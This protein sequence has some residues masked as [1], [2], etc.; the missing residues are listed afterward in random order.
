MVIHKYRNIVRYR[1]M[2]G[3][4]NPT[5]ANPGTQLSLQKVTHVTI[6]VMFFAAIFAQASSCRAFCTKSIMPWHCKGTCCVKDE[7]QCACMGCDVCGT[8]D[9]NGWRQPGQCKNWKARG[10]WHRPQWEQFCNLCRDVRLKK[11]RNSRPG[12]WGSGGSRS[13]S[14]QEVQMQG[15]PIAVPAPQGAPPAHLQ[16]NAA[17]EKI[18]RRDVAEYFFTRA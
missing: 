11:P 6:L 9:M 17:L 18:Q 13:G 2:L 12:S 5:L 4:I 7:Q 14:W 8:W 16:M 1:Q 10:H 3:L 15:E